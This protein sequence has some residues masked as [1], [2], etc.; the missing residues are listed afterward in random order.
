MN[1]EH[2]IGTLASAPVEASA[3][4]EAP[5]TVEALAAVSGP[6]PPAIKDGGAEGAQGVSNTPALTYQSG[7]IQ[8]SL[9]YFTVRID[10]TFESQEPEAI[11]FYDKLLDALYVRREDCIKWPRGV[12]GYD[13]SYYFPEGVL[14]SSG[15][16]GTSSNG[17]ENAFLELKGDSITKLIE[18][19]VTITK[20]VTGVYDDSPAFEVKVISKLFEVIREVPHKVT[21]I[22][23]PVDLFGGEV[24]PLAELKEKCIQKVF[25]TRAKRKKE[26]KEV[27]EGEEADKVAKQVLDDPGW[28]FTIGSRNSPRQLC[29]YDKKAERERAGGYVHSDTWIRFETR[30]HGEM[31]DKR[32]EQIADAYKTLDPLIV[33]KCIVGCLATMVCFKEYKLANDN[34][35]KAPN[36]KAWDRLIAMGDVPQKVKL[37]KS[38]PT[39]KRNADWIKTSTDRIL[40]RLLLVYI[41]DGA[42][43]LRYLIGDAITKLTSEDLAIVNAGRRDIDRPTYDDVGHMQ[44]TLFNGYHLEKIPGDAVLA[45]F[46]EKVGVDI[47]PIGDEPKPIANKTEGDKP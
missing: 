5:S 20:M 25:T 44:A 22:D 9:D 18:R 43:V 40:I 39:V 13:N 11:E 41:E 19:A 42:D 46:D 12:N 23:I 30:Y 33:Q 10:I 16:S 27:I 17:V 8:T 24:I 32:F 38:V 31:A 4:K 2:E 35:Y 14:I 47:V 29:I 26:E 45:L 36:W 21:R 15:G 3:G 7:A 34:T 6:L 1:N 28:S 37:K